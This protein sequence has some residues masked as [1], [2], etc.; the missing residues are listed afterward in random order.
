MKLALITAMTLSGVIGNNEDLAWHLP[1]DLKNYKKLTTNHA[2]IV[3][4]Y[5]FKSLPDKALS[6]NRIY[7]VVTNDNDLVGKIETKNDAVIYYFDCIEAVVMFCDHQCDYNETVFVIGG[8]SLYTQMLEMGY[9][10]YAYITMI[11]D[12]IKGNKYF[13]THILA[14]EFVEVKT[15][16]WLTSKTGI[17]YMFKEY[18]RFNYVDESKG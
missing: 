8:Q 17:E 6:A 18:K 15:T 13:P 11:K 10:D 16:K 3:G 9:C 4:H 5:T 2:C 14:N 12:D 7:F 1:E